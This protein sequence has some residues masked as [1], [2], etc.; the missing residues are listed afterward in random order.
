[1]RIRYT[2]PRLSREEKDFLEA[3]LL[4]EI[5]TQRWYAVASSRLLG[6]EIFVILQ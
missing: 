4:E 5:D 3:I 2:F 6:G 1:M